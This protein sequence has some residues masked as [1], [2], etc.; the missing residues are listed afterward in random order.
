[1]IVDKEKDEML[2]TEGVKFLPF[3]GDNYELGISFNEEG[4]LVLGTEAM[5]GKRVLVLGESHYCDEELS[6]E[7]MNSFTRD[8]LAVY[9]KARENGNRQPWMNTFLKFE[10]ALANCVTDGQRPSDVTDPSYSLNIWNHLIF[11]NYLQV[12]LYGTRMSGDEEDYDAAANPFFKLLELY[13]PDY[14]IVWGK[15]LYNSLP[16]DNGHRG[17]EVTDIC[18]SSWIY[19]ICGHEIKILPIYH[20]SVGFSWDFWNEII[21]DFFK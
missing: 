13:K 11:Y 1:M 20:P 17:K 7:E 14:V 6:Q 10:R 16:E 18:M 5:P 15:R 9:F 19:D 2:K 4:K 3:V 21:V 8:V 12:S